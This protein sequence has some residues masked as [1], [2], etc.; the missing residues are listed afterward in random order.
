LR[1]WPRELCRNSLQIPING[2]DFE[3]ECLIRAKNQFSRRLKFVEI[4]IQTIY[5][6]G[7]KSSNFNPL[8]DSLRIYF[9]FVRYCGVSITIVLIDYF[10]FATALLYLKSVGWS[11]VVGRACAFTAGFFLNK[12]IVFHYN[13][14]SWLS[15]IKFFISAVAFGVISF[16]SIS[17]LKSRFGF[18]VIVAKALIELLL[19]FVGFAVINSFVFNNGNN[20]DKP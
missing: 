2:Y 5:E 13:K 10:I 11:M 18:N 6:D 12:T 20:T 3:M 17:Y 15:F 19:F 14:N 9:V 1:A 8:L 16:F 7:N 4:P